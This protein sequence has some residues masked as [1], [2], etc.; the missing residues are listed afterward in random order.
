[1]KLL[2]VRRLLLAICL[3]LTAVASKATEKRTIATADSIKAVAETPGE[4]KTEKKEVK[5]AAAPDTAWKP[6]RRL[7]G[8]AFGDFYYA[9]HADAGARGAETNYGGV[10][11]YRNAF[12]FRRIYLGYDYDITKKFS[13]VVLLASE[14]SASTG[15][16]SGTST[17]TTTITGATGVTAKTTTTTTTTVANSDNL[18]DGKMTYYIKNIYLRWKGIWNGTDLVLGEQPTPTWSLIEEQAWGYRFVEKT[19]ADLHKLGNSYDVGAGLQGVFDPGTSNFG[20]NVLVGDNTQASLLPAANANTGFYK[21]F[22][23]TLW[24]KFFDKHVVIDLYGDYVKT[25]P[26]TYLIGPQSHNMW[27]GLAAYTTPKFT[28]GV[29]AFTDKI[30]NGVQ[31]TN[32]ATKTAAPADATALGISIYARGAIYKNKLGFFARYDSYN[33]D[34][35]FNT[36]YSYTANT[37]LSSYSP[38]QK[39]QFYTAGL[40]FTPAPNIHFSPNIWLLDFHD[41]MDPS[42]SGYLA[43]DHTLIY[44]LTFFYQFGK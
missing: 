38:Y 30:T 9:G 43:D 29:E 33:P 36:A 24:A 12:Q 13:A 25:A 39:E 7:W 15:T 20:F 14:P 44:R 26:A 1:M 40:D 32:I 5:P 3:L 37:N 34:N 28:A 16:V 41:Q 8:Y 10:P 6:V 18:V 22:Y 11:S 42:T 19:V 23:G 27:K 17:S 31:A 35:D 21:L 4:T 2:Y